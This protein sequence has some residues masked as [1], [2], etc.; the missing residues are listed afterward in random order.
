MIKTFNKYGGVILFYSVVILGLML[1]IIRFN[2]A[3]YDNNKTSEN[4]NVVIA[5]NK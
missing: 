2:N 4:Y 5:Y 3:T 1:H